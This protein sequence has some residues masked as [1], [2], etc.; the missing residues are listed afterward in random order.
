MLPVIKECFGLGAD[1][2]EICK[3]CKTDLSSGTL[4]YEES[5]KVRVTE[6]GCARIS[7][8]R[9]RFNDTRGREMA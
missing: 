6:D 9:I 4:K 3:Q 7:E 8:M 5:L 2:L 1:F